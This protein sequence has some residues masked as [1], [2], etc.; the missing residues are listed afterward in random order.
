[1]LC[2]KPYLPQYRYCVFHLGEQSHNWLMAL[3]P[4]WTHCFSP[5]QSCQALLDP[6]DP[7]SAV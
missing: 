6:S 5:F 7:F 2:D 4:D 1:M 3:P